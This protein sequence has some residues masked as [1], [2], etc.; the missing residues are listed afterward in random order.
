MQSILEVSMGFN[1]PLDT[2]T[3]SQ[4]TNATKMGR[5]M[6]LPQQK[7][8][9]IQND[10][11]TRGFNPLPDATDDSQD[12]NA[13]KTGRHTGLPL[14]DT[15]DVIKAG[16]NPPLDTT[17]D[18]QDT[19]IEK[20]GRHIGLPLQN[21]DDDSE[22][23]NIKNSYISKLKQEIESKKYY[24]KQAQRL[25][26]EGVVEVYFI[27]LK[28]GKITNIKIINTSNY[29]IIDEAALD[30]IKK[31]NKFEPLPDI[32]KVEALPVKIPIKY[33]LL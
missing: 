10:T 11:I 23:E 6:N 18:S 12:T 30:I 29:D 20:T 26:Y 13:E 28:N 27:I 5:Y 31:V 19:N 16:F 24:P 15:N 2:T 4:N 32:F 7:T 3:D 21:T 25:K 17:D 22:K 8:T 33:E 1:P 9:D 14:Q